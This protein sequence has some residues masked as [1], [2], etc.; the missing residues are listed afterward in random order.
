[1]AADAAT[2]LLRY[3]NEKIAE[4]AAP[5]GGRLVGMGAVPLQDVDAALAEL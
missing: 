4:M 2:Q 1:M 5:S 3:M